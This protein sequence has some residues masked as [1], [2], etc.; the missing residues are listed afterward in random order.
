MKPRRDEFPVFLR[1]FV[2]PVLRERGYRFAGQTA[3][4]TR[5][6]ASAHL[7]FLRYRSS[8]RGKLDVRMSITLVPFCYELMGD[9]QNALNA[10]LDHM[11]VFDNS[12]ESQPTIRARLV[13]RRALE[14]RC[15][16][17][18]TS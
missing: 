8:V 16:A 7:C 13:R 4:L 18:M 10:W 3:T 5:G 2:R 12:D 17:Q 9:S 11:S 14:D 15:K 6:H 1:Q